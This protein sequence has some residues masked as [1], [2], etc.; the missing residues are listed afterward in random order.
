LPALDVDLHLA[1][2]R[3]DLGDL[4]GA[5]ELREQ[6]LAARRRCSG[7]EHPDTLALMNNLAAVCR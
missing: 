1:A 2:T 4:H 6:T 7:E 5:R 3:L